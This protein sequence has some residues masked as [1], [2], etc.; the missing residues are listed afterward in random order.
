MTEDK[1][2]EM[3]QE[4]GMGGMP[5]GAMSGVPGVPPGVPGVSPGIPALGA[6]PGFGFPTFL[7]M[8]KVSPN[9]RPRKPSKVMMKLKMYLKSKKAKRK[10]LKIK[11]KSFD[12]NIIPDIKGKAYPESE[13]RKDLRLIERNY[14]MYSKKLID[15][16]YKEYRKNWMSTGQNISARDWVDKLVPIAVNFYAD[17]TAEITWADDEIFDGHILGIELSPKTMEP[18]SPVSMNG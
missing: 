18:N 2:L 14:P 16:M 13:I 17:G 10:Q 8:F 11:G 5:M 3:L 1:Y 9:R 7:N 15:D 6:G 12:L 4:M